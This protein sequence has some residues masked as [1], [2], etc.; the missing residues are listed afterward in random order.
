M[1]SYGKGIRDTR[2][3]IVT[4]AAAAL[5]LAGAGLTISTAGEPAGS[6]VVAEVNGD[7]I[8]VWELNHAAG[9]HRAAVIERYTRD[10]QA[11]LDASFWQ[12]EISGESP[13]EVL[14]KQALEDAVQM[15]I[16]LQLAKQYGFVESVSYEGLME[17]MAQENERRA[18]AVARG[19]PIY[20]PLRF[21]ATAFID[22]VRSKINT[23][24]REELAL[25]ELSPSEAELRDYY[26]HRLPEL[27]PLEDRIVYDRYALSYLRDG[28]RDEELRLEAGR[29]SETLRSQ[30]LSG[31]K[32]DPLQTTDVAVH[33]ETGLVLDSDN[34]SRMYKSENALYTALRESAI[35]TGSAVMVEDRAAGCYVVVYVRARQPGSRPVFEEVRDQVRKVYLEQAFADLINSRVEAAA[36]SVLPALDE[37]MMGMTP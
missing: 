1:R 28:E 10:S 4:I 14:R 5:L 31:V 35:G 16:E 11:T 34:A 6:T 25:G 26:E 13:I 30:L 19:E 36:I 33:T 8:T 9:G 27:M 17:Q 32:L 37:Q 12:R 24:L 23:S 20:G 29:L 7:P 22:F 2:F 15:K 18:A 21:E 3:A